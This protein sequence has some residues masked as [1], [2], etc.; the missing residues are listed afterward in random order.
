MRIIYSKQS[1]WSRVLNY[2]LVFTGGKRNSKTEES[3]KKFINKKSKQSRMSKAF[4]GLKKEIIDGIVVYTYNELPNMEKDFLLYIHGGNF[5]ERANLFQIIFAKKIAKKTGRTLIFPMYEL[6]PNGNC[7][8]MYKMLDVLYESLLKKNPRDIVFLGDS[9]GGGTVLS[10]AMQLRDKNVL[11]PSNIILLSPWIDLSMSNPD[12]YNDAKFD[13]MNDVDGIRYEGKLWADDL[14][15]YDP[16]V[17]PMYGNFDNLGKLSIIFGGRGIL[18]SEC[19]KFDDILS[20][21][22]ID[23][24]YVLYENEGHDFAAYPTFEGGKA[25]EIIVEIINSR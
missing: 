10:Y 17:S 24:N 18:S 19:K 1:L 3:A 23:H 4:M 16:I 20:K 8:K 7:K 2:L 25:I 13:M 6:L 9:A 15:V 21:Q 12:L 5:V 11:Q 14:D 22:N